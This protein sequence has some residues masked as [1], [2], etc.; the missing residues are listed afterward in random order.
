[1]FPDISTIDHRLCV[2]SMWIIAVFIWLK[3][4]MCPRLQ[5]AAPFPLKEDEGENYNISIYESPGVLLW[6][7]FMQ[8]IME[9][10]N[11]ITGAWRAHTLTYWHWPILSHTDISVLHK[12]HSHLY[13]H[14]GKAGMMGG[15]RLTQKCGREKKNHCIL[16]VGYTRQQVNTFSL[17]WMGWVQDSTDFDTS[18]TR[19]QKLLWNVSRGDP[20]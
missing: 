16:W 13:M 1:M 20:A 9:L 5:Y 7:L 12:L 18:P 4:N 3:P 6:M 2:A 15:Q 14:W 17:E 8:Y 10:I 11:N 19:K